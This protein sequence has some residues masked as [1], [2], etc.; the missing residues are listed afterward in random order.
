MLDA[1]EMAALQGIWPR[2]FPALEPWSQSDKL[3]LVV[4]DMAGNAF[5]STICTA[6]RLG[7]MVAISPCVKQNKQL[8]ETIKTVDNTK[9]H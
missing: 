2:D 6:V 3:S 4:K 9:G 7:V 8:C 5:T 1:R